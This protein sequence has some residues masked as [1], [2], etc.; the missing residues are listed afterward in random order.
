MK[1]EMTF[2]IE[3]EK[4]KDLIKEIKKHIH[5]NATSVVFRLKC[6]QNKWDKSYDVANFDVEYG[7]EK[8]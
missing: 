6:F 2:E 7:G 8:C 5:K 3:I 1:K 4:A